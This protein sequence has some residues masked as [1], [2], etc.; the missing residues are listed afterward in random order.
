MNKLKSLHHPISVL[1]I[2]Y[3]SLPAVQAKETGIDSDLPPGLKVQL[4]K[5]NPKSS[6]PSPNDMT[7]GWS[8]V[9]RMAERPDRVQGDFNGDGKPDYALF[10]LEPTGWRIRAYHS[11]QENHYVSFD[12]DEFGTDPRF[13]TAYKPQQF[14]LVLVKKGEILH[15]NGRPVPRARHKYD[16]IELI[17]IDDPGSAEF[18]DWASVPGVKSEF[19]RQ[20]G[21]YRTAGFGSLGNE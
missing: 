14:K 18:F 7:D 12:L 10:L 2:L 4:A 8:T 19:V 6:L 5:E 16:A 15:I 11:D 13:P 9:S 3:A 20:N 1:L 21:A 17:K